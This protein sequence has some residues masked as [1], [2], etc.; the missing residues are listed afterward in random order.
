[1]P[2]RKSKR[3][4]VD[5]RVGNDAQWCLCT[6]SDLLGFGEPIRSNQWR[7]S[8]DSVR[9][10]KRIS[11]FHTLMLDS[12]TDVTETVLLINDG[13][14]RTYDYVP[15][16]GYMRMFRWIRSTIIS[17]HRL[18]LREADEGLPGARTVLAY[19]ER[20]DHTESTLSLHQHLGEAGEGYN[21]RIL[22]YSP[23]PFQMNLAFA[24]AYS[25]DAAG[26]ASGLPGPR[27]FLE[28]GMVSFLESLN[29]QEAPGLWSCDED[30]RPSIRIYLDRVGPW[31]ELM[32]AL[33]GWIEMSFL[34]KAEAVALQALG[35]EAW[36]LVAI[37]P[38]QGQRCFLPIYPHKSMGM[39]IPTFKM[40]EDFPPG[41]ISFEHIP[42]E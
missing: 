36:E 1:M 40:C 3:K 37:T 26:S 6:W 7:V 23:T 30:G 4:T 9:N 29:G 31:R 33:G 27:F 14:A 28:G 18:N 11:R 38:L 15:A 32:V 13:V 25:L 34:L 10:M 24:K 5:A 12:G 19:G 20:L 17:H 39:D 35:L 21:D 16:H 41:H 22:V 42:D 8:P 2:A